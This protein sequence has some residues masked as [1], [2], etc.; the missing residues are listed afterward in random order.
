MPSSAT[1]NP[2]DLETFLKSLTF[3]FPIQTMRMRIIT[4]RLVGI[5]LDNVHK[6]PIAEWALNKWF[7]LFSCLRKTN[8]ERYCMLF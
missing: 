1:Y 6:A 4:T 2:T 7:L 3:H 5:K 8:T